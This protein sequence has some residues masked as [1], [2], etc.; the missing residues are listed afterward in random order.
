MAAEVEIGTVRASSVKA[1]RDGAGTVRMLDVELSGPSDVQSCQLAMAANVDACPIDGDKVLVVR[2][3]QAWPIAIPLEDGVTPDAASGC[4]TIYSRKPD[5]SRSAV[6]TM[7]AAGEIQLN[8]SADWA[9]AYTDLKSA[10]DQL[11]S[12]VNSIVN[13]INGVPGVG[14]VHTCPAGGGATTAMS[15][16][17]SI[18]SADMSGAKVSSVRLP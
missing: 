3:G 9:V 10:F 4:I 16:T 7:T 17:A 12:D 14:H 5:G 6:V 18:S 2:A 11:K 1:N 8:G 13:F 15:G